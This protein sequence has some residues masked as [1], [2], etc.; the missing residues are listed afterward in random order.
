MHGHTKV[1]FHR[2]WHTQEISFDN[3]EKL[4]RHCSNSAWQRVIKS[5]KKKT[6]MAKIYGTNH[7]LSY[8]EE[9]IYLVEYR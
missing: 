9:L 2:I 7:R 3:K 5:T 1:N 6:R 8:A 4:Y